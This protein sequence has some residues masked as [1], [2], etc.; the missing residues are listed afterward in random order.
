MKRNEPMHEPLAIIGMSCLFPKAQSLREYWAN[1]RNK[2]DAI[3]DIPAT[4]WRPEDYYD[5]DP[6]KPDSTY[7]KRGG[8]VPTI[9]FDPVEFGVSPA[10]L[11]A[12][13]ASQLMGLVVAQGAMIDAGYGPNREFDRNRVSVVLGLTGTLQLVIPLGARLG[14]PVW[15]K[16]LK[17]AGVDDEIANEVMAN[18][19]EAYVP[20]QENSFPGLLGN[21]AAGRIANRLNLGG[22]NCIV[23]AA[24]GS[25]L[26]AVHMAAM[27]LHSG[28]ADMVITGG[29]DMFNDIFMYMCFSKTPALSP[30]GDAKPFSTDADGTTLG[31]GVGMVILKRLDKAKADGD[32][33]YALIRGVGTSSDGRGKSIYAPSDAGQEK[34]LRRAYENAGF[35]PETVGLVEAHGTGTKVGDEVELKALRRVYGDAV[36]GRPRCGVGSVKSMIGHT[37]AAAG[38]AGL[39]KAAMALY[40]K[41][42]P[43]TIKVKEPA[44]IFKDAKCPFYLLLEKRPWFAAPDYPRRAAISAL[45]F[46]GSNYHVVLEE[47]DQ[48]KREIDWDGRAEIVALSGGTPAAVRTALAPFKAPL[49][50]AELRKLAAQSRRDFQAAHAC[51]LVFVVEAEKTDIAALAAAADAKL[52]ATPLPERFA[53]PDGAWYETGTSV[54][55]LGVV[56]PG[57]G[58]QYVDMGRDL[59]CLVPETFGAVAKA[60]VTL[61]ELTGGKRLGELVY[62]PAAYD[63][64][65]KKAQEDALRDTRVAQPAIGAVSIG[66]FRALEKFGLKPAGL[67]GHSFGEL[68]ALCAAGTYDEET[69]F[70]L[71]R[72]RGE[73]MA[74]GAGDRG[75]MIAVS[76][77]AADA[78]EVIAGEKLS[79]IIANENAPTQMVL[80][81]STD[82][83]RRAAEIFKARKVRATVL[84][85]AGAFH[86]TFVADAAVPFRAA[87]AGA[88]L[89]AP[90]IPVYANTTGTPYPADVAAI[91][92][93]LGNQLANPVRFIAGV[94]AMYAAGIRTFVEVG[95][96]AKM[97]GLVKSILG[98]RPFTSIGLDAS[99]GKRP[100][101]VDLARTIAICAA[102][103]YPVRLTLWENG[104][105]TL[106]QAASAKKPL[107]AVQ[108]CGANYRTPRPPRVKKQFPARPVAAPVASPQPARPNPVEANSTPVQAPAAMPAPQIPS[109]QTPARAAFEQATPRT[110]VAVPGAARDTIAA[111][112]QLQIQTAELHR[113]FLEGQEQAQKTLQRLLEMQAGGMAAKVPPSMTA[114]VS[115]PPVFVAT[116]PSP[117]P[118]HQPAPAAVSL[119]T[120]DAAPG[121]SAPSKTAVPAPAP[122]GA[123]PSADIASSLLQI[124][125]EKTGYPAEMLNIDMDMESDLGIDSIKR[126]EIMSGVQEKL[127]GA[128]VIQPD[129]LGKLRTLRQIIEFIGAQ[130]AA[131]SRAAATSQHP[132]PTKA[133]SRPSGD[134]S[135]VILQIVS[136]K[137]GYPAEMLNLDMDMESDLG[138]DSIKRV[139]IMSGVQEKLPGAPVIQPDQ[140]GKLRTLRQIIEFIGVQPAGGSSAVT[141]AATT[142]PKAA[143]AGDVV[144]VILQIVSEKTG[145]PAE[146]LNLDMDMESDL[147]I[148]S[149]KRVEIMSGVQEKLPG[150]PVIQ[151]DQLGKLRTLRQIIEFI[152]VQ[153]A[154]GSSAVT[155]AAATAPKAAPADDAV[156]VILQ[157]VSEKTGYPAEMLNLDMDMESDL[158]IDSIKR[159]EIM[160]GVQEKLP[161]APVIQPDQLGKLRTLRQIIEFIGAQPAGFAPAAFVAAPARATTPTASANTIVQVILQIVSEKTGYP[162]EMLNLDMDMESDLGI[163]SIKRVEIMSGVQEKLPD[164]P[165]VQPDQLGKLRSLRQIIEFIGAQPAGAAPAASV[166]AP[167]RATT[168]AAASAN[169]IVEVIL[170]TVSEKTGYP[171]EMLNLDM[172][173]ESDLGI[174]SIKRVEIMSGVQEKLPDAPVV[175][176]DQLGKLRSLRQIIEF[177]GGSPASEPA[178]PSQ[179]AV[180]ETARSAEATSVAAASLVAAS[181]VL[182]RTVVE[183]VA[184][185]PDATRQPVRLAPGSTVLITDDGTPL[186]RLIAVQLAA[187][188]VKPEVIPSDVPLNPA[189]TT[190]VSG[191]IITA[192]LPHM[193]ENGQWPE[194]SEV[195]AKRAFFLAQAAG[196]SLQTM[197][198]KGDAL[199]ATVSRMD[200]AFG[201]INPDAHVDPIQGALAGLVKTAAR[202]WT[203]VAAKAVDLDKAL[204]ADEA[205]A[206]LLV[207]ELFVRGPIESGITSEARYVLVETDETINLKSDAQPVWKADDIVVVTGGARGVTASVAVEIAKAGRP[208]MVLLGRSPEPQAE[209]AWLTG[210]TADSDIKRALMMHAEGR[211]LTPKELEKQY[212]HVIANREIMH[213][214]NAIKA[215]GARYIYRSVD[216]RKPDAVALCIAEIQ[217]T[218]GRI[219]GLVHGAGVLRDRRIAEKT[220]DQFDDVFDT[221][222]VGLRNVLTGLSGEQLKG[223]VLFSSVTG[224]Y[225]RV[226]QVD[227]AMANEALNKI[228]QQ[229]S[230]LHPECRTVSINWGPWDG[231]MVNDGL[232]K[233]FLEEGVGLI[234]LE[235]GAKHLV[236]ELS[237]GAENQIEVVIIGRAGLPEATPQAHSL[238]QTTAVAVSPAPS[239]GVVPAV[240]Q[241]TVE[242]RFATTQSGKRLNAV[243]PAAAATIAPTESKPATADLAG[244][245]STPTSTDAPAALRKKFIPAFERV[246]SLDKDR[247]LT[248][249]ILNGEPV[250]PM[251]VITEWLAHGALHENPGFLFHGFDDLRVLKGFVLHGAAP[252]TLRVHVTKVRGLEEYPKVSAELRSGSH[253]KEIVHA[254]AE[255]VLAE[256][257]PAAPDVSLAP[258]LSARYPIGVS[259]IYRTELFHGRMLEGIT[260]VEGWSPNGIAC[261]A[262]SAPP[263]EQWISSPPR[264]AWLTDPL[265]LDSAYQLMILWTRRV[266]GAPS[267]PNFAG[268]YR[269]YRSAFPTDGVRI[270]ASAVMSGT[271]LAKASIEFIAGDGRLV[272]RMDGYECAV[273]P[274][275]ED[276]FRRRVLEGAVHA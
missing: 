210:I 193:P 36:D 263:P 47:Y 106:A 83:I 138:I 40:H 70:R 271:L 39:I 100:G 171:A 169:T 170:Q 76:L 64:D 99:A 87:V 116:T 71:A 98:D 26:G 255:I 90:S 107:M 78:A 115:A 235:A 65:A 59:C 154:G 229:W 200:G 137:T 218:A 232:R 261:R 119:P 153:P 93:L 257:L 160:S 159:V 128:P 133:Q 241:S 139:E 222:V 220:R 23:D 97:S 175:Q 14:H 123:A 239:A 258:D 68:T 155:Q 256:K 79:L 262:A 15:R 41:T 34:A 273:I 270:V 30:S 246:V 211:K 19:G 60:D 124:V 156:P 120:P 146:M 129:Q 45:G 122:R 5:K 53:L 230:Q 189:T 110:T 272:A 161:A 275:L 267:L 9:T 225:G 18:I 228:A 3:T 10:A 253:G 37:K 165:V 173:M 61:G 20:W 233:L 234:P 236:A 259:D 150:A 167:A 82:E 268:G 250:L 86:S 269:Q 224:R 147:G 80:S 2:V 168:P 178:V 101:S 33:I 163:D 207:D 219:T 13:D 4:H 180:Q 197:A 55:P 52:S 265:V 196:T 151:P 216:I 186:T 105:E 202:E 135:N 158:G 252:Q 91:T 103:G 172:D 182:H 274:T 25:S 89:K 176:P 185:A 121:V 245:P 209:P 130:P 214:L 48:T 226:G 54:A 132:A 118:A 131:A 199:F 191:L 56:F 217:R 183:A 31:E 149:I 249:H 35:G 94:E 177:I 66:S 134:I 109:P 184:Q 157:I 238:R 95:P 213:T 244:T 231:G 247:F 49:D 74:A 237:N 227:Y 1:I 113:K 96:G 204:P 126:V 187:R 72:T 17:D 57:Q 12:T 243:A 206:K 181:E 164:A 16:A 67:I 81:G 108:L 102:L 22:T 6:K 21:V 215:A 125:S 190:N 198:G 251:A 8:F 112:Q 11:E 28:A 85:V 58:A 242:V 266:A 260:E 127:P 32:K 104:E 205:T 136:E 38:S 203:G 69:L 248:S 43:P 152:G 44:A 166:A 162:A 264:P 212:Q 88:S 208:T 254:R 24:C 148:D 194:A 142:A 27:E 42:L 50:S 73:L 143:P 221:K 201:L 29:V 145:Y 140:L 240:T 46:G 117:A 51:R 144:P 75:G 7:S 114:P 174:D 111:L 77:S 195:F 223:L 179:T 62:P 92:D 63:E 276:A 84:Q 192:P 188:G 141:Q